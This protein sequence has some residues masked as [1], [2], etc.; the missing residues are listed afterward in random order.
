MCTIAKVWN[1]EYISGRYVG[2]SPLPF[3]RTILTELRKRPDILTQ[4]GLYVE[5]GNGRNYI[6]LVKAGLY[7]IGLDISKVGI[8]QIIDRYPSFENRL[9]CEDFVNFHDG[10]FG[11]V[12]SIQSFQHGIATHVAQY[13][14]RAARMLIPCRLLFIRVNSSNTEVQQPHQV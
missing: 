2:D 10:K 13:F 5:D 4:R 8:Q 12:I 14:Q 6:P 7:I 9:V 11:Y 3:T 1:A